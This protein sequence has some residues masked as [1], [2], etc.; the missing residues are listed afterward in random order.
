MV[1][2]SEQTTFLVIQER[3]WF[4][5]DRLTPKALNSV[6]AKVMRLQANTKVYVGRFTSKPEN[7]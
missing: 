3:R 5:G 4:K 2:Q 7:L 6:G 1:R